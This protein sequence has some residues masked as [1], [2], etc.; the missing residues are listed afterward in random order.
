ML[1]RDPTSIA[2]DHLASAQKTHLRLA[3]KPPLPAYR[4]Y[5]REAWITSG[6]WKNLAKLVFWDCQSSR[7]G[8]EQ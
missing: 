3:L 6:H 2:L 4:L 1:L 7:D 8:P 5:F